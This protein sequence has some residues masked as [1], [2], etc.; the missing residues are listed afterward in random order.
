MSRFSQKYLI[1]LFQH[2]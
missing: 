1:Q 2:W